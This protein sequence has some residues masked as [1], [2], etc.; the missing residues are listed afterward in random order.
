LPENETLQGKM[1]AL[2]PCTNVS[3]HA[4]YRDY[5]PDPMMDT[6]P[7][8]YDAPRCEKAFH[9][10][11][12]DLTRAYFSILCEG[13]V[14]G[15]IYLKRMDKERKTAEFGIALINDSV[16]GKGYGT[17][18]INLLTEYAF[19]ML[20][21]ETVNADTVLRNTRSQHVLEKV[22]FVYTHENADFRYYKIARRI[23][24]NS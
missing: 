16:K 3:W 21:L 2:A 10:R 6:T 8:A 20:G 17:E 23:P 11:M 22:G 14:I 9:I 24:P 7:Y 19:N 1:I 12:E 13:R 15:E 18:A 4:F 5:E